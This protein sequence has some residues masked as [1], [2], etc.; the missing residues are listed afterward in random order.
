[1]SAALDTRAEIVKLTRLLEVDAGELRFLR[2]TSAADLAAFREQVTESM[3][4]GGAAR[5]RRLAAASRVVPAQINARIAQGVM[6]PVLCARL[7]GMVEPSK[8]IDVAK[9]LPAPFLADVAVQ[10][11]PRRAAQVIARVP[12][13]LVA[14]VAR[15]LIERDEHVAMG[16]FVGYV[17]DD[18]IRAAIAAIDDTGLLLIAF[19][20]EG[21]ER[22]DP[23]I[24]LLPAERLPAVIRA[25]QDE[26]LWPEALDLLAHLGAARRRE[27]G[28]LVAEHADVLDSLARA[29]D[30]QDLWEDVLPVVP[31]LSEPSK[32]NVAAMAARLEQP[33]LERVI[34]SV[35]RHDLWTLFVPLAGDFMD[36][37]GRERVAQVVSEID[38]DVI[39]GLADAVER[40]GLWPQLLQIAERMTPAQ[41]DRIA[42]RLLDAGLETRLP[43]LVAAVDATGLWATGLGMLAGLPSELQ[44]KLAAPAATLA[45]DERAL[46]LEHALALGLDERLG[47]IAAALSSEHLRPRD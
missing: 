41:L 13:K 10:I 9:H 1:V 32:R 6:G 14:E 35:H 24:S 34:A 39:H 27:L 30:E 43:S 26:G 40:D 37:A 16:R 21:K 4:A 47:P 22:L 42:G 20:M 17:G 2:A 36:D 45:P 29:A 5:L 23:L 18:G 3:F 11:D 25:A 46:V 15:E 19:V 31:A 8:A 44:D 33:I 28:E 12:A 38:D 7:A